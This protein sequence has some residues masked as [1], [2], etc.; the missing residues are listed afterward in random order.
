MQT[1]LN[2]RD[3]FMKSA[4]DKD[5][6]I[7]TLKNKLDRMQGEQI[8]LRG[9]NKFLIDLDPMGLFIAASFLLIRFD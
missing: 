3:R 5:Q 7:L 1:I 2:Q 9:D 4:A 6:E 8:Q